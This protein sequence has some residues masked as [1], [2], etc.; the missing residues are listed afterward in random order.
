MA[1]AAAPSAIAAPKEWDDPRIALTAH[2]FQQEI[3]D[4]AYEV[5]ATVVDQRLF[6]AAIHAPA[7]HEGPDWRR[8]SDAFTHTPLVLPGNIEDRVR[9]MM[10][11]LGL[12]FAALDFIVDTHGT[13]HLVDVNAGGQWAW[14]DST[15]EPI[16][17]A[18]A[19]LLQ[20][21]HTP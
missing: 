15:R 7:G 14:I 3:T 1:H 21:G 4:R 10:R 17:D 5:R 9:E 19:D 13:H 6:A 11:R 18:I 2:L 12:V 16:T 8:D 20:K